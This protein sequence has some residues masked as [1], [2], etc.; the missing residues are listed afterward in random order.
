MINLKK[1]ELQELNSLELRNINGG[2]YPWGPI[3]TGV[4]AIGAA[5]AWAFEKGEKI[6]KALAE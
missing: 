3:I 6:G 2:T 5:M 4:A 1:I